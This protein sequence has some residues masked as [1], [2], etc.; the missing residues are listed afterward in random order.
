MRELAAVVAVDASQLS[1]AEA[2]AFCERVA[3]LDVALAEREEIATK[4]LADA[5]ALALREASE[6]ERL[7]AEIDTVVGVENGVLHFREVRVERVHGAELG[8]RSSSALRSVRNACPVHSD[9]PA[10]ARTRRSSSGA[11]LR[12]L[13]DASRAPVPHLFFV[14][15]EQR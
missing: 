11:V 13:A 1:G 6:V 5:N 4:E 7:R 3:T 15:N 8:R 12:R 10:L 9:A 2:E 14:C